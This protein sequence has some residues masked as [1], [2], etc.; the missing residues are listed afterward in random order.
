MSCDA[1]ELKTIWL[2]LRQ[3]YFPEEDFL[4]SYRVVWSGRK[5]KRT[6]ASCSL[7]KRTVRVAGE[8]KPEPL[9]V[10]LP[11]LL[12]HE[13]CHAYLDRSVKRYHCAAFKR[14][15]ARHPQTPALK[16]WIAAGGWRKA[17]RSDR[18]RRTQQRLREIKT[19][20]LEKIG[21]KSCI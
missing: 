13:M 2:K 4:D 5:Q 1:P 17:V 19:G 20:L 18:S 6:L 15:E 16:E 7:L 10:W 8:L 21:I 3:E 14:L 11:P 12:Y 9:A